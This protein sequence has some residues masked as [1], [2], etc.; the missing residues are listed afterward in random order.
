[1]FSRFGQSQSH[2]QASKYTRPLSA[3]ASF[4]ASHS[5]RSSCELDQ[6]LLVQR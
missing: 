1:M 6:M 5:R 4:F 2:R 3:S